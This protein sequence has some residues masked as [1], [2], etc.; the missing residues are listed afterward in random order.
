[1]IITFPWPAQA[2]LE[3]A[4]RAILFS[5]FEHWFFKGFVSIWVLVRAFPETI[6]AYFSVAHMATSG[7]DIC[8]LLI[9]GTLAFST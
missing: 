7:L 2:S 6:S 9:V 3:L 4:L 8:D 5:F 1:M